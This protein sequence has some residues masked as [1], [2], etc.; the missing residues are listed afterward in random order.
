MWPSRCQYESRWV[1]MK[2]W[3]WHWSLGIRMASLK[4]RGMLML[5]RNPREN[6]M[7]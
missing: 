3:A 1:R 6:L 5:K 7:R 2:Q 4:K